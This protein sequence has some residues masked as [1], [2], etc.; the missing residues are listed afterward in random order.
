MGE[1]DDVFCELYLQVQQPRQPWLFGP[2]ALRISSRVLLVSDILPISQG[3]RDF[4]LFLQL[5]LEPPVIFLYFI[6][7]AGILFWGI[8][9]FLLAHLSIEHSTVFRPLDR[10]LTLSFLA[11]FYS[12]FISS[13]SM[14]DPIGY[15]GYAR[16][17]LLSKP[18]ICSELVHFSILLSLSPNCCFFLCVLALRT[19]LCIYSLF[20]WVPYLATNI[21]L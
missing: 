15:Y 6:K 9:L 10:P 7:K 2:L 3:Q 12:I 8:L 17:I 16:L 14:P 18:I 20:T 11:R 21:V 1:L 19:L 5:L 13:I 4:F